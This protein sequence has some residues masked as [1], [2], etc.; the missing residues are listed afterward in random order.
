LK[1]HSLTSFFEMENA[2]VNAAAAA[3]VPPADVTKN[4]PRDRSWYTYQARGE[5]Q[6]YGHDAFVYNKYETKRPKYN[7]IKL[8]TTSLTKAERAAGKKYAGDYD[9]M[10]PDGFDYNGG[11]FLS[12]NTVV[13]VTIRHLIGLNP[14]LLKKFLKENRQHLTADCTAEAIQKASRSELIKMAWLAPGLLWGRDFHTMEKDRDP[15]TAEKREQECWME[16]DWLVDEE[17]EK[18]AKVAGKKRKTEEA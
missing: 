9:D 12:M 3:P 17:E 16:Y 1:I 4:P 14:T 5:V 7:D 15:A 2:P 11:A 10:D 13:K 18:Q 8:I 6:V